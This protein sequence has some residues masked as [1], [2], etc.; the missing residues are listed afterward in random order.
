MAD[1]SEGLGEHVGGLIACLGGKGSAG[2]TSLVVIN[3]PPPS[4][5][6]CMV[7]QNARRA[8]P[9]LRLCSQAEKLELED[10]ANKETEVFG[11]TGN[12]SRY[13]TTVQVTVIVIRAEDK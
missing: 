2:L 10:D 13:G 4:H 9:W 11:T 12:V 8:L 6:T 5:L 3:S 1:V 7:I